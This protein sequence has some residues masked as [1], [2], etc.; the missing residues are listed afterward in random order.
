M[1]TRPE[2]KLIARQKMTEIETLRE[3]VSRLRERVAVLEAERS[4]PPQIGTGIWPPVWAPIP[5]SS[6]AQWPLQPPFIV[7]CGTT[8]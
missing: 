5:I 6:P 1:A 7:T 8:S 3:E 2:K 4:L